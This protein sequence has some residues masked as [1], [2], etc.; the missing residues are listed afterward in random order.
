MKNAMKFEGKFRIE[1]VRDG[2]VIATKEGKNIITNEGFNSILD[3]M[4]GA[5]SKM[6]TWYIGLVNGSPTYA[7]T[8]TLAAHAGWT[9]GTAYT[10]DRKIWVTG[11]AAS[12]SITNATASEFTVTGAMD[13]YGAFLASSTDNTGVLWCEKN[14]STNL[15][16]I[17]TDVIRVYYT[18]SASQA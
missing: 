12:K 13:V 7:V 18:V 15:S 8:D 6:A 2:N 4:F 5:D 11:A 3:V 9:E 14:F 17:A 10:G 1:H 16:V